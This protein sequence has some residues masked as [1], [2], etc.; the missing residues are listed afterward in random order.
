[1][2]GEAWI[3]YNISGG[4]IYFERRIIYVWVTFHLYGQIRAV[5]RLEHEFLGSFRIQNQ[6]EN[7]E[8]SGY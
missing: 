8:A 4:P 5:R 2:I 7:S 3:W 6:P 1:M